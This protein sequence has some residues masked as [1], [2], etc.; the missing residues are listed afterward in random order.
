[1]KGL[2]EISTGPM[3]VCGWLVKAVS[4]CTCMCLSTP[5]PSP[6]PCMYMNSDGQH[7][8]QVREGKIGKNKIYP[9]EHQVDDARREFPS[10]AILLASFPFASE[11][12]MEQMREGSVDIFTS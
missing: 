12:Y 10:T 7:E 8:K 9:H 6:L 2:T 11:W 5:K 1:M 3:Y 4:T